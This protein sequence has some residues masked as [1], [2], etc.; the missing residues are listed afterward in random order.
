MTIAADSAGHAYLT[1]LTVS[2]D[3]PI[4]N[5][6]QVAFGGF[7]DA[8]VAKLASDGSHL[9]YSSYLGGTG[10]D[11]GRG[12]AVDSS[13][14]VYVT[15]QTAS[16]DF[17]TVDPL[18]P[19]LAGGDTFLGDGFV[20]RV[21]PDGALAYSTYFGGTRPD[22][23][24]SVAVDQAQNIYIAGITTSPDFPTVNAVQPTF[25][26]PGV[27]FGFDGFVAKFRDRGSSLVYSTYLGGTQVD[28]ARDIAFDEQGSAYV[29]GETSSTNF[30]VVSPLQ[31]ALRGPEDMFVTKL[32]P[33]G[34]AVI[35]STYL[36][37]SGTEVGNAIAVDRHGQT[38]VF[39]TTS[40]TDFPTINA[41]QPR[42]GGAR[43]SFIARLHQDGSAVIHSSYL[44]ARGESRPGSHALRIAPR[45]R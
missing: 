7:A 43:D 38:H 34:S 32:D 21:A 6:F 36:G 42:L 9:V 22:A 30:P 15:G 1:G 10:S 14:E 37:G 16:E 28:Q 23:G 25:G 8:F 33:D 27:P 26:G 31:S 17:P 24:M 12:I 5:G 45:K 2:R 3:F 4:V 35:F 18:Q 19:T 29:A 39:G 13:G 40:S 44:A 20:A 41:V 11:D